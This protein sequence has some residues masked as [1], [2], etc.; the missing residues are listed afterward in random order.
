MWYAGGDLHLFMSHYQA[1]FRGCTFFKV[2]GKVV[3]YLSQHKLRKVEC[4]R[5]KL[6]RWLKVN[7]V[8]AAGK[9]S[10]SML[11]G[12]LSGVKADNRFKYWSYELNYTQLLVV[13]SFRFKKSFLLKKTQCFI[14]YLLIV[15]YNVRYK[16]IYPMAY[17]SELYY[18]I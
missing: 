11:S 13:F 2:V 12:I 6:K 5:D 10:C 3:V 1:D 18:C 9:L 16:F 8:V 17:A 7:R 4:R 14:N 15:N